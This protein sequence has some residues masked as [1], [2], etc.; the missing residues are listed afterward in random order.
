MRCVA[1][2]LAAFLFCTSVSS[3][4]T[5]YIDPAEVTIMAV[6]KT[7][8]CSIS[9]SGA[10]NVLA[11][12]FKLKQND[13]ECGD[14]LIWSKDEVDEISTESSWT[15]FNTTISERQLQ[16]CGITGESSDTNIV[17]TGALSINIKNQET[18]FVYQRYEVPFSLVYNL[19]TH[20][21]SNIG[22]EPLVDTGPKVLGEETMNGQLSTELVFTDSQGQPTDKQ[23]YLEGKETAI[24]FLIGQVMKETKGKANPKIATEILIN[25]IK[26]S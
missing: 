15:T 19:Y 24:R 7:V 6:G 1:L 9:I 2:L 23:D 22:L 21:V 12:Q 25:Q 17:F 8:E 20:A 26:K 16:E 18:N 13:Q 4:T 5:V 3:Q 10:E 11:Y 14:S